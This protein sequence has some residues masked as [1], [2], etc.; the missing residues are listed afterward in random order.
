MSEHL[1]GN[2]AL[3]TGG[4][5]GLGRGFA[6]ALA[7]AG[8]AV[9]VT[10]RTESQVN[11]T[12]NTIN[13]EGGR[14]IGFPVDVTDQGGMNNIINTVESKF[15]P[16]D[17][18]VNNAGVVTPS[19]WDWEIEPDVWWR[20]MEINLK[21]PYICTRA[22]LPGMISR[23]Q[24]RIVNISSAGAYTVHP[25]VTSYC[26]AK[27]A[28]SHFTRCLAPAVQEFGISVFAYAPGYVRTG[29]TE[30]LS[31]SSDMPEGY[32][33]RFQQRFDEG[34]DDSMEDAVN[35]LIFLLSGKA[36]ALT[37]RHISINDSEEELLSGIDTI[38]ADNLYTLGILK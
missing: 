12:V 10:A 9:A 24:G 30:Y 33:E 23:R 2:V 11:E 25:Y 14:A 1:R 6:Q 19:G 36:D 29:V 7:S 21:G 37:G 28:L 35:K 38:L 16:I 4:G 18:L 31:A 3:V 8:S 22:I 34:L 15:G 27:A 32:T 5:R 20:S 17:I 13:D 26:A